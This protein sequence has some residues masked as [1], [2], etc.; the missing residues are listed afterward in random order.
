MRDVVELTEE[1][2]SVDGIHFG[3]DELKIATNVELF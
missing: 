1:A 3:K 2:L